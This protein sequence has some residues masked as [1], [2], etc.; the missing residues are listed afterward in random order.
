MPGAGG[1]HFAVRQSPDDAGGSQHHRTKADLQ[2]RVSVPLDNNV[3][4]FATRF[5]ATP[6]TFPT[7]HKSPL[8]VGVASRQGAMTYPASFLPTINGMPPFSRGSAN[9]LAANGYGTIDSDKQVT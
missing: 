4:G 9:S 6:D 3:E 5:L 8:H 7:C 2:W 1:Q